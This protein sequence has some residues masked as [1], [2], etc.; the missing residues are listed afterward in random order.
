MKNK[1]FIAFVCLIAIITIALIFDELLYEKI[2]RNRFIKHIGNLVWLFCVYYV[3]KISWMV[4]KV[5]W[6]KQLWSF[7]YIAFFLFLLFLGLI[8]FFIGGFIENVKEA[9]GYT[10]FF[11]TSPVPFTILWLLAYK[12][13]TGT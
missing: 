2:N 13:K 9:I 10:R 7:T 1:N 5:Q 12:I 8:D 4:Y 6:V 3:G 11:F